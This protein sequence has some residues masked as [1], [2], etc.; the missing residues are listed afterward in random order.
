MAQLAFTRTGVG[1]PLVLLHGIGLSR[2]SWEPVV[3][4]LAERFDVIAV[5]LPG[6][7][8]S[9]SLPA[10]VEPVPSA[11]AAAVAG[12][13][14]ELGVTA[15]HVA[16]NSLGGWVALEL[17]SA[18]P[19]ASLTLLSPAGLWRRATPWYDRVSLRLS[20]WFPRHA[21]GPLGRLVGYRLGRAVVLGQTH[22]H[23]GRLTPQ[24]ARA[25]VQDMGTCTGF[26]ATL[27]ATATRRFLAAGPIDAPVT[28]AFGGRDR[29]LLR[30]QSRHLDQ[31]PPGTR[32]ESLPGCGHIPMA[33][34]P[35]AVTALI[36][37]TAGRAGAAVSHAEHLRL[38]KPDGIDHLA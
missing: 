13:L 22:G 35:A 21:G 34:D 25:V 30:R 38:G 11:L 16:G 29:L 28:V 2:R 36:A 17:A 9:E 3:P 5:D 12:L 31:L 1:A 4:A 33:D 7:G 15:P 32:S 37:R 14:D 24:Y 6:F 20:R 18:R 26:E 27:R 10:D 8:G 19:A 23:P